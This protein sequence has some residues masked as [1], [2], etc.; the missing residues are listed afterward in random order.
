VLLNL[1]IYLFI[2]L[3]KGVVNR[4]TSRKKMNTSLSYILYLFILYIASI[5]FYYYLNKYLSIK[6]IY[7]TN[8]NTL[9]KKKKNEAEGIHSKL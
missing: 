5:T 8:S 4:V 7:Q 2:Y 6:T 1:F 3:K 9:K